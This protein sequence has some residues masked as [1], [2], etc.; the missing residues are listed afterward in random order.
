MSG[1][2]RFALVPVLAAAAFLA[3]SARADLDFS[4]ISSEVDA[5][6]ATATGRVRATCLGLQRTLARAD[7]VG[8]A[9]DFWKLR[10]VAVALAGRLA[11]DAALA[12]AAEARIADGLDALVAESTELTVL[13]LSLSSPR[14]RARC[15]AVG[16][17]GDRH[18]ADAMKARAAGLAAA[19]ASHAR[20]AAAQYAFGA[21]LAQKLLA[22]QNLRGA[23][24]SVPLSARGGSLL[25]V[26]TGPGAN[27]DVY[28]V[29]AEDAAGPIFLR[30]AAEGWVRVPVAATG[31][32]WW[33]SGIG[34]QIYAS[35]TGGRVVRYDPATGDLTDL[36][37]G[38]DV[39]LYGVWGVSTNDV[40][41]VGGNVDGGLP[42]TALLHH[43]GNGWTSV[44]LP[45]EANNR[46][47]FKVWGTS[48]EDVWA[49]GQAG[50]VMHYDGSEWSVVPGGTF[51]SLFTVHGDSPTIIVGGA[52]EPSLVVSG[53]S[54]FAP[55][56]LPTG[57]NNLRGVFQ[58]ASGDA[59]AAG[60]GGTVL[61]RVNG[62]W[63]RVGGL[64]PIPANDFHAVAV[65]DAGGVY[66][67][68]GDLSSLDQGALVYYG[69]RVLPPAN[70][71]YTQA[72]LSEKIAPIF[73]ADRD[74]FRPWSCAIGGCHVA[75][76]PSGNLDL[77]VDS[78]AMWSRLVSVPSSEST[79]YRVLPGRPSLSYLFQKLAGVQAGI[80]VGNERMPLGGPYL[81]PADM[82]AVRAWILEGARD[83]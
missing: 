9:D 79:L 22:R 72:K 20:R 4:T 3:T 59:W 26:W 23:T 36:S 8:L 18:A 32:L 31:D 63:T 78:H 45:A 39:T 37:T 21:A 11:G 80:G 68:G 57:V 74:V 35:G 54:G 42:R 17:R 14:D 81:G 46:T 50:L 38:V 6:A 44:P 65:D 41:T 66:L 67:A 71:V 58:T 51:E 77:F 30:M 13:S 73:S 47:L 40:W 55:A 24:W 5:R 43:D 49:C 64:P 60:L 29:G 25:S 75:A 62:R 70:A 2:G 82:D 15:Q 1:R 56:T 27:P 76:S 12:A 69:A 19:T 28:V 16:R 52:V 34:D 48:A 10:A 53:P 33:V 83:N 7:R 61:R